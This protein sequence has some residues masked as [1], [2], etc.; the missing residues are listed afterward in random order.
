MSEP[1]V[2]AWLRGGAAVAA[3][4]GTDPSA[5]LSSAEASARLAVVGPNRL[6]PE[7]PVAAWRKLLAQFVDPL[8]L[9]LLA[10][11]AISGVTWMLEGAHGVPFEAVVI[12]TIL[13]ANAVLGYVQ[14]ARA[15]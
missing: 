1:V 7:P 3:A 13:V 6:D 2:D 12:G 8:V 5:G 11:V 10:A 15:E 14:E 9:L 4:L